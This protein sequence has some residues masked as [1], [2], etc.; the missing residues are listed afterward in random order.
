MEKAVFRIRI[1][2]PVLFWP[3]IRDWKKS[4][5]G[6]KMSNHFP[7]SLE[8]VFRA[9]NTLILW[10][11]SGNFLILHPGSGIRNGKIGSGIRD[12]HRNTGKRQRQKVI[13]EAKIK[14]H[15]F[16]EVENMLTGL[17]NY[18]SDLTTALAALVVENCLERM[19]KFLAA[20]ILDSLWKTWYFL[21]LAAKYR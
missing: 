7:E 13:N 18:T 20:A 10:C 9:K 12:K 11:G 21:D 19:D 17:H 8:I 15:D 16:E 4:G 6:M 2:D 1:R 14:L 3:W 5:S